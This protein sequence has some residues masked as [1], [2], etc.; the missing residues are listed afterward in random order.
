MG[1]PARGRVFASE[2]ATVQAAVDVLPA[3]GGVVY[4][5]G[6]YD[7]TSY[8]PV[9][10]RDGVRLFGSSRGGLIE[11]GGGS[12]PT[13]WSSSL[14][15]SDANKNIVEVID[16]PYCSI[17][18]LQLKGANSAGTQIGLKADLNTQSL[19]ASLVME[20]VYIVNCGLHGAQVKNYYLSSFRDCQFIGNKGRGFY[21]KYSGGVTNPHWDFDNC[22]FNLNKDF[23]FYGENLG[24]STFRTCSFQGNGLGSSGSGVAWAQS[25]LTA[26]NGV[27]FDTCQWEL[28]DQGVG[29]GS[30]TRFVGA[31]VELSDTIEWRN[32]KFVCGSTPAAPATAIWLVDSH[33]CDTGLMWMDALAGGGQPGNAVKF[34]KVSNIC[35][36]NVVGLMDYPNGNILPISGTEGTDFESCY[37]PFLQQFAAT[38][39]GTDGRDV[40]PASTKTNIAY[41]VKGQVIYVRGAT[42]PLE[43]WDGAA[44]T[45]V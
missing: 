36:Q 12:E 21:G 8:A 25:Y 42:P 32:S 29:T 26:S 7:V 13:Y 11:S 41:K 31:Y 34:V 30:G 27:T 38:G 1:N 45:N 6:N 33:H 24:V 18:N 17:R 16:A 37:V 23:G 14:Y 20:N 2:Y 43:Y 4:V 35:K 44:W 39:T 19:S 3:S 10:L 28:I 40:T 9:S 15:C 5:D 22:W